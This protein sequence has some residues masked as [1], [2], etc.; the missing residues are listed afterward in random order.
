VLSAD[1]RY[2]LFLS[3]ARNMVPGAMGGADFHIY[4]TDLRTGTLRRVTANA[5]G[6]P[7]NAEST[8]FPSLSADGHTVAFG[9][10]ASNLVPHDTN[11]RDDIFVRRF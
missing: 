9:S 4:W 1:G 2:L 8:S 6:R 10:R 11:H 5:A 7:A 3:A